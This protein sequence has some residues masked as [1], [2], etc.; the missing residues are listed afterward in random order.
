MYVKIINILFLSTWFDKKISYFVKTTT[1]TKKNKL[2]LKSSCFSPY[3][4]RNKK[5]VFIRLGNHHT[6]S[7]VFW[8]RIN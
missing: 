7:R 6:I 4:S 2:K 5:G 1:K 8:G 3:I